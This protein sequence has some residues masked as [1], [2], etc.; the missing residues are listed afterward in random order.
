MRNLNEMMIEIVSNEVNNQLVDKLSLK[1]VN[2]LL[3][4]SKKHPKKGELIFF[5]LCH[6]SQWTEL[7]YKCVHY[8]NTVFDCGYEPT[9]LSK[10][11]KNKK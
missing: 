5:E 3:K 11:F 4:W 6:L 10:F 1:K 9:N 8:L 2:K 7:S